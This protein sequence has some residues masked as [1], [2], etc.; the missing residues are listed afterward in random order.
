MN[1]KLADPEPDAS[2]GQKAHPLTRYPQWLL[3]LATPAVLIAYLARGEI[4]SLSVLLSVLGTALALTVY[5]ALVEATLKT[6]SWRR[7]VTPN[8][9]SSETAKK[10]DSK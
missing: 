7:P 6:C 1:P 3:N 9:P 10:E 4:P 5:L 8:D 2:S